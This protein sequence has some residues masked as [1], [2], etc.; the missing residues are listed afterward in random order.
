M[1]TKALI[2]SGAALLALAV[3]PV[4]A[5]QSNTGTPD[6]SIAQRKD[7]QQERIANGVQSGQLTAGETKRLETG[8][9]SL[10][11][12]ESNMRAADDGHL[13]AADRTKLTNQQNRLSNRIY[14]DKHNANTAHYGNNEVGQRRENQQDRIAQGIKSGQLTAGET[15]KLERQQQSINREDASMRAANGGKL[16]G[17]DKAALNQRQNNASKNIYAK[18]HNTR[19]R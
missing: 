15:A 3:S 10:N 7:N 4:F 1:K 5:Q 6:P 18:K 13:T 17:A 9:T 14:D 2:C 8:E 19:T 16:T 12:E 11:R